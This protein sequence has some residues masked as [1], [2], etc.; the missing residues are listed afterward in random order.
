[1][2]ESVLGSNSISPRPPNGRENIIDACHRDCHEENTF[3]SNF[4]I[5]TPFMAEEKRLLTLE[6][7]LDLSI[8]EK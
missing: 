8:P 5:K 3:L 2:D 4:A 1:M 6:Q 7:P